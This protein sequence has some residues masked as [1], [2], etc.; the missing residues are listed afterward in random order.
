MLP[1]L[2]AIG[3]FTVAAAARR[4]TA[5]SAPGTCVAAVGARVVVGVIV[6]VVDGVVYQRARWV[7]MNAL[8]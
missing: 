5:S 6:S 7:K 2:T 4:G 8:Q 3:I 1:A